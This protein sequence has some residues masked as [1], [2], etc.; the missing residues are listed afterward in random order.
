MKIAFIEVQIP[1]RDLE[2]RL[3]LSTTLADNGYTVI[4]GRHH[5]VYN[6]A[7]N[8]E[9][10][11]YFSDWGHT[12]AGADKAA[13]LRKN[14]IQTVLFCEEVL[15][16]AEWSTYKKERVSHRALKETAAIFAN[17]AIH[18]KIISEVWRRKP[19]E[20]I[21]TGNIRFSLLQEQ[22]RWLY[23]AEVKKIQQEYNEFILVCTNGALGDVEN[24]AKRIE[25]EGEKDTLIYQEM[26]GLKSL[27]HILILE[28]IRLAGLMPNQKFIIRAKPGE[29][30]LIKKLVGDKVTNIL[31][32]NRFSIRPWVISA[33]YVISNCC[34]T[35]LDAVCA[36]TPSIVYFPKDWCM[37]KSEITNGVSFVY[38]NADDIKK[39]IEIV[40]NQTRYKPKGCRKYLPD[41]EECAIQKFLE[42]FNSFQ[43]VDQIK[44]L[45]TQQSI[46]TMIKN[47]LRYFKKFLN[48][49]SKWT[50]IITP[51]DMSKFKKLGIKPKRIGAEVYLISK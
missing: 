15:A 51:D 31:F 17:N 14:N 16:V 47:W 5:E 2:A 11:V 4:I 27:Q 19:N 39:H 18:K 12:E 26:L 46:P 30:K 38:H 23:E 28:V 24:L 25:I 37:I 13:N 35:A 33:S 44:V 41:I 32:D 34:T 7:M 50:G 20:I 48:G 40:K 36:K 1:V 49:R 29:E 10:G 21:V 43:N 3:L 8:N 22:N 45:K 42:K 9:N 6:I